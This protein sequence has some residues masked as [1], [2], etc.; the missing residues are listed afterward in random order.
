M[1]EQNPLP[2]HAPQTPEKIRFGQKNVAIIVYADDRTFG[3]RLREYI[4]D[5]GICEKL[6]VALNINVTRNT[7]VFVV[8]TA[9]TVY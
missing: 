9:R 4:R 5:P 8:S 2:I 3:E 1:A 7:T 6:S